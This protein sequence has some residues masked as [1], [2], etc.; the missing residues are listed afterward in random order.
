MFARHAGRGLGTFHRFPPC[1]SLRTD[2]DNAV[3]HRFLGWTR[4]TT[5]VTVTLNNHGPF[6]ALWRWYEAN[7]R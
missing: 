1:V 3:G 2:R 7:S 6:M 5:N 4:R